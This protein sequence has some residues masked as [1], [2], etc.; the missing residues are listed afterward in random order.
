MHHCS[1]KSLE[2]YCIQLITNSVCCC[3]RWDSVVDVMDLIEKEAILSPAQVMSI[4]ALNPQL[5][6]QI[7]FNY[8]SKSLKVRGLYPLFYIVIYC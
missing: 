8:I 4:L 1:F 6:L 7:A 3:G 5:P 2:E